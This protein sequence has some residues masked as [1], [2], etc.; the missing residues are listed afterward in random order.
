MFDKNNPFYATITER[1][2]LCRPGSQKNTQHI[3]LDVKNSNITYDVGDS[4]AIFPINDPQLVEKT[5][6][7]MR[8]TG[9][10]PITDKQGQTTDLRT[11]LTEKANITDISRKLV[12]E[13]LKKCT[14][15]ELEAIEKDH[16]LLKEYQNTHEVWDLLVK[17]PQAQFTPDELCHLLMPMLPRFY[18][19]ASS[20]KEVGDEIHLTVAFLNYYTS[21]HLRLGVCTH[22]LCN[23]APKNEAVV[24]IYI[25]PHKGFTLPENPET[26]IIMIGPGTGIAPYR[27]FMQER[28][29]SPITGNNWLFF[30]EWNRDYNYFYENFWEDL[31]KQDKLKLSLAFSRDQDHKVYVQHRMKEEGAEFFNWLEKGAVVYVCGDAHHMAKDVDAALHEIIQEHGKMTE[32]AA[33]Q[34]VK[35]LKHSKRYLRDVY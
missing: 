2:S 16:Q 34:Y 11:H 10:E 32:D 13:V 4:V 24:P 15:P 30:G 18:S 1:H 31:V 6:N 23:L 8:A 22:Y 21:G 7:A 12:S 33:K 9:N 27:A 19:I 5:L 35:D 20:M 17:H 25:H 28:A 26:P 29:H 14:D 3:V